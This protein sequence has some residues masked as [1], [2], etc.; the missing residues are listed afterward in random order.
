ME[1]LQK[2]KQIKRKFENYDEEELGI[3]RIGTI[4]AVVVTLF[5]VYWYL[6]AKAIGITLLFIEIIFLVYILVLDRNLPADKLK[7]KEVKKMNDENPKKK[8]DESEEEEP[9]EDNILGDT[10]L[11]NAEEYNKRAEKALGTLPYLM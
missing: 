7:K 10:G 4:I 9:E 11:P 5:G 8:P 6:Q 3:Y 1:F 2:I